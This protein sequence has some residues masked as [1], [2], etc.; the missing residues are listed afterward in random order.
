MTK[1]FGWT[2]CWLSIFIAVLNTSCS[3]DESGTATLQIRLTDGPGD[4]SEVNIDIQDVQVKSGDTTNSNSGWKSLGM[5]PGVHDLLKLTNGR[6]TLLGTFDLPPGKISQ[7]RLVLGSNNSVK[8]SGQSISLSTPSAQQSG[9]KILINTTLTAGI[10]YKITL[11]FD[12]ARSIVTTGNGDYIL[13]PVIRSVATAETGAIAG[14]VSPAASTPAVYAMQGTTIAATTN[15]DQTTG[16][17]LL[18]GLAAGSYTVSFAPKTG[19]LA[20]TVRNVSVT[21]GSVTDMGTVN[22]S[23]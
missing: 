12:A 6:D 23:Q 10:V 16:K 17:Y 13:K 9:L 11:D 18:R 15:A 21:V 4:Y 7:I 5:T 8:V 3:K 14:T 1:I 22:I 2:F 19:Y 20:D